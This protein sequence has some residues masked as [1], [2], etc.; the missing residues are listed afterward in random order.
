MDSLDEMQKSLEIESHGDGRARRKWLEALYVAGR[1]SPS[2]ATK[3]ACAQLLGENGK[4]DHSI[5]M[6]DDYLA[7]HEIAS[8]VKTF[9]NDNPSRPS[10]I[11]RTSEGTWE[12]RYT[13]TYNYNHNGLEFNILR[14]CTDLDGIGTHIH[15][16]LSISPIEDRT[17]NGYQGA[18]QITDI[19]QEGMTICA[20]RFFDGKDMQ[21][22]KVHSKNIQEIM[23]VAEKLVMNSG[24]SSQFASY[25]LPAIQK[26]I[27]LS[28][29]HPQKP[30]IELSKVA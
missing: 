23:K 13:P 8:N 30:R 22:V 2:L 1:E 29:R 9:A 17:S 24:R 11:Q 12:E 28:L 14:E 19:T 10:S 6:L 16:D 20:G 27:L 25:I 26:E 3:I 4:M 7:H 21:G 5:K 18:I 15:V